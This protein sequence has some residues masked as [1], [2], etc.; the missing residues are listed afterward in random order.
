[1]SHPRISTEDASYRKYVRVFDTD[2][3]HV[4]A[5]EGDPIVF[6]HGKPTPS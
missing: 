5:G 1:M 4:D 2:T 3:A 6:L